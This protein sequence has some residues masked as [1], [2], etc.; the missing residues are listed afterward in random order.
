MVHIDTGPKWRNNNDDDD[1]NDNRGSGWNYDDDD[2][3]RENTRR[4]GRNGKLRLDETAPS[5]LRI[6]YFQ[7]FIAWIFFIR[8]AKVF[9]GS[10]YF[11]KITKI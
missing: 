6:M 5:V 4:G 1:D 9:F 7:S 3:G 8:L 10:P 2:G 11:L